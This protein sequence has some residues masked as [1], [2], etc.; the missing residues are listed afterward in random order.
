MCDTCSSSLVHQQPPQPVWSMEGYWH[1]ES[2]NIPDQLV[3]TLGN[4]ALISVFCLLQGH[5]NPT[6]TGI[7]NETLPVTT[8]QSGV[9]EPAK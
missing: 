2:Q 5:P 8:L 1:S 9:Q 7:N 4:N 6:S 3:S